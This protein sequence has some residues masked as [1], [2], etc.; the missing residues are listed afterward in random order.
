MIAGERSDPRWLALDICA[1]AEH[2]GD[3]LLVVAAEERAV[4]AAVEEAVAELAAKRSGIADAP[5]A[6]VEVPGPDEAVALAQA[7]APEHL[8]LD[9]GRDTELFERLTTPGCVFAGPWGATAFGDYAAGSNHILP[10]G[11]AGR[12]CGP[13]GPSIFRRRISNVEIDAAAAAA[14]APHVDRLAREEGLPLHGE[15]ALARAR[16]RGD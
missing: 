12:F 11:G 15:S 10:T 6:L 14:L 1:Q 3:G 5:L 9:T 7:V 13:L 16:D 2:G 8:Q 4:L